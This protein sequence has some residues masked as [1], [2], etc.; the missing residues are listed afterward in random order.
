MSFDSEMT[1]WMHLFATEYRYEIAVK[2]DRA[3]L[4]EWFEEKLPPDAFGPRWN[5]VGGDGD[6]ICAFN[7]DKVAIEF[8]LRFG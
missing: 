6:F 2:A 7:D 5:I 4:N 3:I 1:G 8:K